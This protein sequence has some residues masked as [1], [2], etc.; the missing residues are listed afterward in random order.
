VAGTMNVV[1]TS[2]KVEED[3]EM[4]QGYLSLI[5][6]IHCHS[7]SHPIVHDHVTTSDNHHLQLLL[8]AK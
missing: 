5:M 1:S 7:F 2:E 6:L 8:H 3:D 4:Q